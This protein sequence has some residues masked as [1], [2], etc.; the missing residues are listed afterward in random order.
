MILSDQTIASCLDSGKIQVTPEVDP[1]DIRPTGI[2]L[3]LADEILIPYEGKTVDCTSTAD[4]LFQSTTIPA[5]GFLMK[6]GMF[7]LGSTVERVKVDRNIV[8]HL[9]GRSTIAR[10]GLM[11]HCSSG[12]LD[13][14]HDEPR[15]TTLELVNLGKFDLLL[16]SGMPIAEV[17][18]SELSAPIGQSSQS[19][20]RGQGKA[21]PPNLRFKTK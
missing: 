12:L 4:D 3:H 5:A 10:L 2:R 7:V 11:I 8:C 18:F 9:E 15:A 17:L 21:M 13:G 14:N 20:Y 1:R 16:R 19:Q 6:S